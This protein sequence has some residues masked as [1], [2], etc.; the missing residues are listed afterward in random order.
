[1]I[2]VIVPV[3]RVEQYLDACIESILA[4]HFRTLS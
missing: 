2:S 3:Y 1:M 4:K